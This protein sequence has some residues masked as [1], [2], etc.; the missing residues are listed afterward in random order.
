MCSLKTSRLQ[1]TISVTGWKTAAWLKGR[2]PLWL[3]QHFWTVLLWLYAEQ[4]FYPM[5]QYSSKIPLVLTLFGMFIKQ[6]ASRIQQD[7]RVA[8]VYGE[9]LFPLQRFQRTG[10]ISS[11]G[12]TTIH[13]CLASCHTR[14][15]FYRKRAKQCT[16]LMAMVCFA[17]WHKLT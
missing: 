6:I 1:P 15:V 9:E 3:M 7:K 10:R 17:L 16:Q 4:V 5:Y 12:T 13:N 14:S 8:K 11:V 2:H